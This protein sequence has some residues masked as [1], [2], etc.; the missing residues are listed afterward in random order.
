MT[1]RQERAILEALDAQGL[2]LES[3]DNLS[4]LV[5]VE[6]VSLDLF[7]LLESAMSEYL[8]LANTGW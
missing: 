3:L 4:V 2:E 1:E 6:G 5:E 8:T 7:D